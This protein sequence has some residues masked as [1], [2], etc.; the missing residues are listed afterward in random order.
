MMAILAS[1][2]NENK[3]QNENENKKSSNKILPQ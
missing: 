1:E 3:K 2:A